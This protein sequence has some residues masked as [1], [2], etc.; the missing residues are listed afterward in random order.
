[1]NVLNMLN[2]KYVIQQD[3][4]GR[5]YPAVNPQANGNAWFVEKVKVVSTADYEIQELENLDTKREAVVTEKNADGL[6]RFD[7]VVDSTATIDW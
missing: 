4:E 1:M 6:N 3:E 2:V 7:F 5:S